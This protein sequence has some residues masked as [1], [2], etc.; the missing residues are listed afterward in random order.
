MMNL[1][2][3]PRLLLVE[4]DPD[5][6]RLITETLEGC[7]GVGC[8]N[9]C[10]CFEEA[11]KVS[12]WKIDM[13]LSDMDLP[14]G[15]GLDLLEY[16]ILCRSD[17]PVVFVTAEG[18]LEEAVKAIRRGAYDYIVKTGDYLFTIPLIVEKNLA[19]WRTKEENQRLHE[20]LQCTLEEIRIKNNQLEEAVQQLEAVAATDPL[21]GLQNRRSFDQSLSRA[22]AVA[23]RRGHDIACVMIDVDHF[24]LINDSLGH[25][26]GDRL[27]NKIARVLESHCRRTTTLS[28]QVITYLRSR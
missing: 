8:V 24:K 27:L 5:T 14:D 23:E 11:M 18:I 16:F 1:T 25:Q 13:V 17:L 6:A 26:A 22:I 19:I 3:S 12:A 9:V 28:K 15:N 2:P 4:D 20:R 21:T 7:F 10:G